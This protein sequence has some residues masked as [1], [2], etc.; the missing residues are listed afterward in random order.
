[1]TAQV[2]ASA[3]ARFEQYWFR[4]TSAAGFGLMRIGYGIS[5]LLTML[6]YWP[7]IDLYFG[8]YGLVTYSMI[9][10]VHRSM[11]RM[12][13]LDGIGVETMHLFYWALL[14]SLVLVII[15][16]WTRVSLVVSTILL[17]SFH[18]YGRIILNGGD[19]LL[20]I[21]AFLLVISP[22]HRALSLSNLLKRWKVSSLT[23][24][25]QLPHART[26][27]I[28]PYR[29]LLWQLIVLYTASSIEKFSGF[30]WRDGSAVAA[31]LHH[32]HFSR[33]TTELADSLS[34][35]SPFIGYFT[36]AAQSAWILL[37]PLGLLSMLGL[38]SRHAFD[39]WKRM[40]ILCGIVVHGGIFLMMDVGTFSLTIC[41]A[42]LGL[43]LDDDF[44][45]IRS[46]LNRKERSVV[47]LFDGRCGFCQKAIITLKSFDWLQ[48]LE[49]AN[50]HDA[51]VRKKYAPDT[52]FKALNTEMH[53]RLPDG[54]LNAGFFAFR[55]LSWHF[56]A[57]WILAPMLY[58][59]GIP[60]I[61]RW[62]YRWVA[63]HR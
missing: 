32:P 41:V 33:L 49:F 54:T 19:T 36:L 15:G 3:I 47:V 1:M 29:L 4:P 17:F 63:N 61:G 34:A 14:V 55:S 10:Y 31:V 24:K 53:V 2:T 50:Y 22:C 21:I 59:P 44:D 30:M 43:L 58:I 57:L 27:P 23:G 45:A 25:D 51:N 28:W 9:Q 60:T 18:E 56:P 37:L 48:R 11:W 40:L 62:I 13:L 26:M 38:I 39:T 16:I 52:D 6:S 12:S 35:T 42:Y 5:A 46:I 8:E 20:R 7:K